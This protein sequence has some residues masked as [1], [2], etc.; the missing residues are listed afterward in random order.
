MDEQR[1][2][3]VAASA[4]GKRCDSFEL[5]FLRKN[6][7]SVE[8][9]GKKIESLVNS[10]ESGLAIRV[11]K[12]GRLGFSYTTALSEDGIRDAVRIALASSVASPLEQAPFSKVFEISHIEWEARDLSWSGIGVEK[13]IGL[14]LQMESVA[15]S[16]SPLVSGV[17][18]VR[19]EDEDR[20]VR[21]V[22]SYGLDLSFESTIYECSALVIASNG[23]ESKI[24]LD[25]GFSH[26]FDGLKFEDV[27]RN[28]SLKAV[29]LLGG[30]SVK[31]A[32]LPIILESSVSAELLEVFVKGFYGNNVYKGKSKV[33]DLLGKKVYHTSLNLV[34]DPLLKDGYRSSPFDGEG[35]PTHRKYV[36]RDG[37]IENWLL[38]NYF[39]HLL[40]TESNGSSRR[41]TVLEPPSIG[42]SNLYVIPGHATSDLFREM[43]NGIYITSVYGVHTINPVTCDF[44][45]GAEGILVERGMKTR[46]VCGIV[47]SGNLHDI[48]GGDILI[49]DRLVF[50]GNVGSPEILL[51]DVS[52][53][54]C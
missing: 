31:S 49:G 37:T 19:Y 9:R 32:R 17:K 48:F 43:W 34:D 47:I 25:F 3:S 29:S 16:T 28:A 44:S 1:V 7:I 30:R 15:L 45:L 26:T 36:I 23:D 10:N 4:L 42:I 40:G 50:F 6:G 41:D 18:K 53:S 13:K 11:V 39:G 35:T 21:I 54:G 27:A 46:P 33:A 22:N 51:P 14:A 5:F 20:Y 12:D 2:I 8:A 38:D 24:A 52:I